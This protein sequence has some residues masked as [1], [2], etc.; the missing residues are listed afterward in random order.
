GQQCH[1]LQPVEVV[2]RGVGGDE[3]AVHDED[4]VEP[5]RLGLLDLLHVPA[6]VHAGVAGDLRVQPLEVLARAAGSHGHRAELDLA[7]A[8]ESCPSVV[9]PSA[10]RARAR[11]IHSA[12]RWQATLWRSAAGTRGGWAAQGAAA[13]AQRVANTQ[14]PG[15]SK[16]SSRSSGSATASAT[17]RV[18]C[19]GESSRP[20]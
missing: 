15:S 7:F 16:L 20:G 17:V 12:W 10:V 4:Q 14:A 3:L 2:R 18:T 19:C 13:N 11:V 8:H 1:W 6:D 9:R 5:G